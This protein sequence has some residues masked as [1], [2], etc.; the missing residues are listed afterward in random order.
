MNLIKITLLGDPRS[1]QHCYKYRRQGNFISGYMDSK[2]KSL[3]VDY[4]KQIMAQYTSLPFK[5]HLAVEL[6][7]WHGTKRKVDIDNFCKL[8][9]DSLTGLVYE[10][11]SQ[12]MELK[13]TKNY[14]KENPR[15]E[16]ILRELLS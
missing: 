16:L 11:D 6:T 13:I 12:I 4:K 5:Q 3:K 10:D 15:A 1:T 8:I 14:D 7:L 2:C 9:F